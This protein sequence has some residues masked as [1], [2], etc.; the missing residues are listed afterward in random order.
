MSPVPSVSRPPPAPSSIAAPGRAPSGDT[1]PGTG[2]QR[3]PCATA[4]PGRSSDILEA[5]SLPGIERAATTSPSPAAGSA[6]SVAERS[7]PET[8]APWLPSPPPYP[9]RARSVAERSLPGPRAPSVAERASPQRRTPRSP[10]RCCAAPAARCVRGDPASGR[11]VL[12]GR[13]AGPSLL[14]RAAWSRRGSAA[15]RASLRGQR[16]MHGV[17][18]AG[19]RFSEVFVEGVGGRSRAVGPRR[20]GLGWPEPGCVSGLV[21]GR[22][23]CA[24]VPPRPLAA[25]RPGAAV[26]P[27]GP[28][29]PVERS[30][31]NPSPLHA[32]RL[33]RGVPSRSPD[34]PRGECPGPDSADGISASSGRLWERC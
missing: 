20:W 31:G 4:G 19:L 28:P 30:R 3:R 9:F 10:R 27:G 24:P 32:A 5:P 16:L 34:V 33:A 14:P 13:P 17:A 26:S 6:P 21:P 2:Q 11:G 29:G 12:N 15:G 7:L 18:G 1:A 22:A 23:R 8:R 25:L